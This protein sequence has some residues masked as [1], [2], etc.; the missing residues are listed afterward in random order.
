MFSPVRSESTWNHLL[1]GRVVGLR[2]SA[3][4]A[5]DAANGTV[6]PEEN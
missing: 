5:E 4:S 2:V 6:E 3:Q 1:L